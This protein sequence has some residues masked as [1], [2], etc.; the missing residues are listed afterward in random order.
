MTKDVK[1]EF[2][3][4]LPGYYISE[5]DPLETTDREHVFTLSQATQVYMLA[6]D[7]AEKKNSQA[8]QVYMLAADDAEKKNRWM[9][10]LDRCAKV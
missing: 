7:D 5:P 3:I 9:E 1:A 10:V 4:P 8:T 2:T 6:A